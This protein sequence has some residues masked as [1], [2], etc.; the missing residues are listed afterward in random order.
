M[1][2]KSYINEILHNLTKTVLDGNSSN[3]IYTEE[4]FNHCDTIVFF[5]NHL[6][7]AERKPVSRLVRRE[8]YERVL[9]V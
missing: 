9:S 2:I 3:R 4:K 8:V 7:K 6:A 5:H 1:K